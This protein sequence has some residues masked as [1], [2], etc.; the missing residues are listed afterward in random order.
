MLA[1]KAAVEFES[2]LLV[3]NAFAFF[4]SASKSCWWVWILATGTILETILCSVHGINFKVVAKAGKAMRPP[5]SQNC[6]SSDPAIDLIYK[7]ERGI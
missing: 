3:V 2:Q 1:F 6:L 5:R 4:S 7:V